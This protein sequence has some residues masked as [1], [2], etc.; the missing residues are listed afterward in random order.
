MRKL[1]MS[2][3]RLYE[4]TIS[5]TL[6]TKDLA[7]TFRDKITKTDSFLMNRVIKGLKWRFYTP[8]RQASDDPFAPFQDVADWTFAVAAQYQHNDRLGGFGD[9]VLAVWEGDGRNRA[10]LT[11][12]DSQGPKG[13]ARNFLNA[14]KTLDGSMDFS[15]QVTD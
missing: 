11:L 10:K 14:L 8:E 12:P 3:G 15:E 1:E 5:T 9:I 6:S 4:Y 7:Y 2:K 13:C